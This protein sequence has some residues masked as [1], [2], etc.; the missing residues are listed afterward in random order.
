VFDTLTADHFVGVNKMIFQGIKALIETPASVNIITLSDKLEGKVPAATITELL[1][2]PAMSQAELKHYIKQAKQH[3][4]TAKLQALGKRLQAMKPEHLEKALTELDSTI[5]EIHTAGEHRETLKRIDSLAAEY[6]SDLEERYQ[7]RGLVGYS[8]TYDRLDYLTGG[9]TP[10]DLIIIGGQASMGKSAFAGCLIKRMAEKGTGSLMFSLEMSGKQ[11]FNRII[12]Q[13]TGIDSLKLK[14]G[15]VTADEVR[16]VA[17]KS[18]RL[19]DK[20]IYLDD[21]TAATVSYIR[22]KARRIAAIDPR[23]KFI[24]I[25]YLQLMELGRGENRNLQE[26]EAT[27]GLKLLARELQ[28]P[29][30]L[31]SQLNRQTT[32]NRTKIG[33]KRAQKGRPTLSNLRE[34]GA[35]EQ[36]ADMVLFAY[37]EYMHDQ[38]A[39]ED[40]AEIIVA[41]CREGCTGT[42]YMLW[43]GSHTLFI[44]RGRDEQMDRVR[45]GEGG[46]RADGNKRAGVSGADRGTDKAAGPVKEKAPW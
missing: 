10:G 3:Y 1:E 14:G 34:S 43:D 35:I 38:N 16:E 22:R 23:V 26:S 28:M 33:P 20:P 42:S 12:S 36:D 19:A 24:V 40:E 4:G 25:D 30:I 6:L 27:R 31:L 8:T 46:Y 44:E 9:F 13:E 41:K 32:E 18:S 2:Y 7:G 45:K 29:I 39:P 15:K 11:I 5:N 37:R 17:K 21:Y